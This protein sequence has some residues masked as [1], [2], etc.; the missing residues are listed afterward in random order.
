MANPNIAI[1]GALYGRTELQ[2]ITTTPTAIANN[3][4]SSNKIF[5][6]NTLVV[7]NVSSAVANITADIFRSA[8]ATRLASQIPVPA[9]SVL[10]LIAKENPIYLLEGDALRLTAS[11][12]S[13]LHGV[14][15]FE[16]VG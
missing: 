9:Q 16:E 15:S 14:C 1:T 5:K 10:V 3:S 12:N 6:I 7:T 8:T 13:A 2:Q 11:A 4:S